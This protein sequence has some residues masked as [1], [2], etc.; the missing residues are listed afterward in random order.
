VT[1][2]NI[3]IIMDGISPSKVTHNAGLK[4]GTV[5]IAQDVAEQAVVEWSR[6]LASEGLT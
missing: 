1:G 4:D 2:R 6:I 3:A 5:V